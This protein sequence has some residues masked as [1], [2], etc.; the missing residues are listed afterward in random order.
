MKTFEE[1]FNELQNNNSSE[2]NELFINLKEKRKKAKKISLY[3]IG[4]IDIV[5]LIIFLVLFSILGKFSFFIFL[6][7]TMIFALIT[8]VLTF[9]I[10]SIILKLDKEQLQFNNRY[11]DI[12]IEKLISNFYNNLEY[13][14]NKEMPRYIYE[15]PNYEDFNKY[16]SDDYFEAQINNKHS[17]QMAEVLTQ[18]ETTYKDS[19]GNT[20]TETVTRFHGLFAKIVIDKS[21]NSQL[22]IMP[23]GTMLFDKKRLNMDSSEFE[24]HFDIKASNQII[25]MQLLTAD[26]MQDL[27]EFKYKTNMVYDIYINNNELYLRFHSGKMFEATNIKDYALDKAI[28]NKYFY[29]LNFTYNLSNKLINIINNTQI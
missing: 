4:A 8:N 9:V 13:F 14:P 24:K 11:K 18:K 17:I 7:P 29:M 23:N 19:E 6:I 22:R 10:V 15:Q 16:Y 12:V 5:L 21:I 27:L 20:H 2:L 1:I 3:I 25:A 28:I 26:I